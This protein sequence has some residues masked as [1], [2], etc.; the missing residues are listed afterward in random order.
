MRINPERVIAAHHRELARAEALVER[1]GV[2]V[3]EARS[4]WVRSLSRPHRLCDFV[5]RPTVGSGAFSNDSRFL[6]TVVRIHPC[7]IEISGA[8]GQFSVVSA[9]VSAGPLNVEV[10]CPE[11]AVRDHGCPEHTSAWRAA[12]AGA[13][14]VEFSYLD[15]ELLLMVLLDANDNTMAHRLSL[16]VSEIRQ[17]LIRL[18]SKLG[19]EGRDGLKGV[20]VRI[21]GARMALRPGFAVNDSEGR[22]VGAVGRVQEDCFELRRPEAAPTWLVYSAVQRAAASTV[23]LVCLSGEWDALRCATHSV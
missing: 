17:A 22:F 16:P 10:S 8:R 14:P 1:A 5:R 21:L 4:T 3:T 13:E 19:A 2:V 15:R 6:G 11:S 7:C 23:T 18:A 20:A 12:Q 9:C